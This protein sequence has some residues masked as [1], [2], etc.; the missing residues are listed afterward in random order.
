MGKV[1]RYLALATAVALGGI[2]AYG[3][4]EFYQLK[5][6]EGFIAG[7][8]FGMKQGIEEALK[9][10]KTN[11]GDFNNDGIEDFCILLPPSKSIPY[12]KMVC[13]TDFDGDCIQDTVHSIVYD[14]DNI[15]V[16][17]VKKGL[18]ILGKC[19]YGGRSLIHK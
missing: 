19:N 9:Q 10:V 17:N 8:K 6:N 5:L 18:N 16:I 13:H 7:K 15:E 3:A 11:T 12:T 2:S 14:E 1:F 4:K